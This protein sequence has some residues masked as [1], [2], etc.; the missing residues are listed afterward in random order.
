MWFHCAP[1]FEIAE[2]LPLDWSACNVRVSPA[3]QLNSALPFSTF[4]FEV[5]GA[6]EKAS[7]T[8]RETLPDCTTAI[9]YA[10]EAKDGN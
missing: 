2:V 10:P 1:E 6:A 7:V 9:Q 5:L 4:E 3:R 8:V